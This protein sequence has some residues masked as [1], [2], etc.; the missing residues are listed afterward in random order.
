MYSNRSERKD[1]SLIINGQPCWDCGKLIA[2][3]GVARL[4]IIPDPS[5]ADGERVNNLI[6]DSGIELVT[7]PHLWT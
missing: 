4:V 7:V 6:Q 3:S 2:G 1:G 5:Y